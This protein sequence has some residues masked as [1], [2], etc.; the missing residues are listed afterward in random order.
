MKN[1]INRTYMIPLLLCFIPFILSAVYYNQ[2]PEQVAIHFDSSGNPDNYAP[3]L[4]AA[5]GLPLIMLAVFVYSWF[6]RE[7]DPKGAGASPAMKF[8]ARWAIPVLAIVVQLFTISYATGMDVNPSLYGPLLVGLM[9][10]VA[11]NYL[12]KCRQNY[13]I[14]IKLPW[15]LHD[16]NNWNKTHYL[17]GW[18]WVAGGLVL[19]LNAFI[20]V[21]WL[22]IAV[23][24][25]LVG[26]P[27]VYS[28]SLYRRTVRAG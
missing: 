17:A 14:G 5:F 3:K 25:L 22:S 1:K 27:F 15:T 26:I 18:V 9:I 11:G 19:I 16:E 12:P 4:F 21:P 8:V 6:R 28:Y 2:L 24:V 10:V 13:T 20:A 7:N 23:I